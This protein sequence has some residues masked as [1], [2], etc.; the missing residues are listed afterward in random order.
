MKKSV[1][2][3]ISAITVAALVF[4]AVFGTMAS[5]VIPVI[6]V[7][8]IRILPDDRDESKITTQTIGEKE[9]K[10]LRIRY[11]QSRVTY[12]EDHNP[13]MPY[14]FST[15][16]LPSDASN[17]KFTYSLPESRYIKFNASDDQSKSRGSILI[18]PKTAEEMAFSKTASVTV[19]V[20]ANDAKHKSDTLNFVVV[21]A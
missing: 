15:E 16:I 2:I 20:K 1:L 8:S 4:V 12:D 14:W 6:Y 11:D 3:L 9:V 10:S 17:Q 21:Y 13:C 19:T 18:Y 5:G 7:S